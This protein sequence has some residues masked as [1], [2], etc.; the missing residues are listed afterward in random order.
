MTDK[1]NKAEKKLLVVPNEDGIGPSSLISLVV[2]ELLR[3]SKG[4]LAVTIWNKS[5]LEYNQNLYKN[6]FE[7]KRVELKPVWNIIQLKKNDRG[8]VSIPETLKVIGDYKTAS[9][10]YSSNFQDNSFD[11]VLDFGVP[12]AVKW[13]DKF[14]IESV[15]V[16]DHA[17][18][19][20]LR[21][22]FD[23]QYNYCQK[24]RPILEDHREKWDK[25]VTEIGSDE[26]LTKNLFVFPKFIT[27]DVFRS[28]WK[29]DRGV[30]FGD[31]GAAL[32]GN[33]NQTAKEARHILGLTK[34]GNAIL[35]QGGDTPVWDNA[36]RKVV[37]AFVDTEKRGDLE[38]KN[39]NIVI[40]IPK[41]LH[42]DNSIKVI[43]DPTLKRVRKLCFVPGG[44]IQEILPAFQFLVTR[45]GGGSVNDA[46]ACRVPF[47]CVREPTQSQV[48]EILR[49]CEEME[50][51][52]AIEPKDF[53]ERPTNVILEHYE[54]T[55]ANDYIKENMREIPCQ[56][57]Q[58][59]AREIQEH[60]RKE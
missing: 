14:K 34:P 45:A 8:K 19:K 10:N 4:K 43:D 53:E 60:L 9:D 25:L 30:S 49:K 33:P 31:I 6:Y 29:N 42:N 55:K 1:S 32:G 28:Y 50:L 2:K 22:I 36:L 3:N 56:G 21:M 7:E 52:R 24:E 44:T 23:D 26:N 16:F 35:I 5:H 27:P 13:A 15:S 47:V 17:W 18:G 51:T 38:K 57:E 48:E 40:Y 37:P 58:R 46:V 39:L 20:T 54:M 11:L 12:A 41:R 59:I